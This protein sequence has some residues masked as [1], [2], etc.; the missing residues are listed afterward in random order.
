MPSGSVMTSAHLDLRE[1]SS[2]GAISLRAYRPSGSWGS[3]SLTWSNKPGYITS[4]YHSSVYIGDGWYR[5]SISDWAKGW[6]NGSIINNGVM[7][8][9]TNESST[10]VWATFRSSDNWDTGK[11]P[12]LVITT[13]VNPPPTNIIL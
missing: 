12:R 1:Y 8:K 13:T 4:S 2:A 9:D 11:R 7:I 3:S 5:M 6:K 10:S